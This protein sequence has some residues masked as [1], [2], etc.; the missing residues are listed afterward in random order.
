ML[1]DLTFLL[2]D[3]D[4]LRRG[5]TE[6]AV[7]EREVVL[8]GA[9][10]NPGLFGRANYPATFDHFQNERRVDPDPSREDRDVELRSAAGFDPDA[11]DRP[12]VDNVTVWRLD[13]VERY[14]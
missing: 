6:L 13:P 12:G 1:I 11:L 2:F 5:C 7:H 14:R 8:P 10:Q 3:L 4:R 9:Q